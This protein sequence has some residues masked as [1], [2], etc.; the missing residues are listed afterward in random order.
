MAPQKDISPS[1]SAKSQRLLSERHCI[2][3]TGEMQI[4]TAELGTLDKHRQ[5][6]FATPGKVLNVTIS[7]V[8][9]SAWNSPCAL[10]ADL[11]F[12]FS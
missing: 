1:P 7:T 5:V 4:T 8:L 9:W 2:K 12:E 10:F 11:L 6:H 3:L